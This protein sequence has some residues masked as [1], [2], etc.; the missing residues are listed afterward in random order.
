MQKIAC[1]NFLT[2][3]CVFF[4]MVF[5]FFP[6]EKAQILMALFGVI[7]LGIFIE[8]FRLYRFPNLSLLLLH[9]T[10]ASIWGIG[11]GLFLTLTL[12]RVSGL[13]VVGTFFWNVFIFLPIFLLGVWLTGLR[14]NPHPRLPRIERFLMPVIVIPLLLTSLYARLIEPYRLTVKTYEVPVEG[15]K[16]EVRIL[17]VSDT[18]SEF[19]GFRERQLIE[20]VKALSNDPNT[21]PDMILFTGD[22][23]QASPHSEAAQIKSARYVLQN[24]QE[25]AAVFGVPGHHELPGGDKILFEGLPCKLLN[26]EI[27]DIEIKGNPI[28]LI[29][30]ATPHK[31]S[32]VLD[33]SITGRV[34]ILFAHKPDVI[35]E[36]RHLPAGKKPQIL[37]AGHTHGGQVILPFIGAPVDLSNLP[38]KYVRGLFHLHDMVLHV[39]A[40]VGLE[41]GYAPHVRFNSPPEIT[42]LRL[43][44]KTVHHRGI[45]NTKKS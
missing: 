3:M 38:N 36:L 19:L 37:F 5:E 32:T 43:V 10:W 12:H 7:G 2:C 4:N 16:S 40:G 30:V 44:P 14:T 23:T 17:H 20:R 42:L 9:G 45:A 28:R 13:T 31:Q 34:N 26:N 29:G 15:L 1:G 8:K 22:Y 6:G 11:M 21:R 27:A 33:Q 18:Q 41:G 25:C 24:L 39:S 35:L